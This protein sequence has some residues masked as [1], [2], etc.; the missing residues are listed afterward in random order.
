MRR[1]NEIALAA[2]AI[3]AEGWPRAKKLGFSK[4][5]F[6]RLWMLAFCPKWVTGQ[7]TSETSRNRLLEII[8]ARPKEA[9]SVILA[10]QAARATRNGNIILKVLLDPE[11]DPPNW[12]LKDIQ[13]ASL[14]RKKMGST[15]RNDKATDRLVGNIKK[16]RQELAKRYPVSKG[17]LT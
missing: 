2:S 1:K 6:R 11:A 9:C 5:D 8:G 13:I 7:L 14:V 3:G 10:V 15:L 12:T 4:E 16:Q 17:R